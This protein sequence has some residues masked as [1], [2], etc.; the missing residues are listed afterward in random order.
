MV[1]RTLGGLAL[2]GSRLTRPKPL[3]LLAFLSLEGP[4]GRREL[5]DLFF[6]TATDPRDGLAT[7]LR[8]LRAAG[9]LVEQG[10]EHV[11]SAVEADASA[12]LRDF[13]AYR[14]QAVLERY[15]GAFL[16]G[17][18]VDLGLELEEWLFTTREAIASR[19]RTAAL[20]RARIAVG[21]GRHQ[22]ARTLTVRALRLE[23]V[24]ELEDDEI[25]LAH[26][27]AE[28]LQL[29]EAARLRALAG[30]AGLVLV[31]PTAGTAAAATTI[32]GE[33]VGLHR[34]TRF[35][36]RARELDR[37]EALCRDP[38][39]RLVTI[40]GMGGVGKT[41]LA[42]RC[43]ERALALQRARYPDGVF[44]VSLEAVDH[45]SDVPATIASALVLPTAAVA[46]PA[47]LQEA[48]ASWRSLIVLDNVEHV[49]D[50]A[51]LVVGLVDGCP[52]LQLL[53]TSR[54]RLGLSSEHVLPL[55]GLAT[56]RAAGGRSD[57]AGLFLTRAA[58]VGFDR[59][60]TSNALE[61]IEALCHDLEGY[62][63]GIELA[64][65]WT[66][67]LGIDEIRTTLRQSLDLLVEGPPDAPERHRAV[68]AALEPSWTLAGERERI[69]LQRLSVFRGGFSLDAANAVA[70]ATLPVL[71]RLVDDGL[72]RSVGGGRGRFSLHPVMRAFVREKTPPGL[73]AAASAAHVDFYARLLASARARVEREPRETLERVSTDAA[74][75][76]AALR[77][78]LHT[79]R[80]SDAVAMAQALVVDL[81][82]LQARPCPPELGE[83]LLEVVDAAEA[84]G[85]LGDVV[86]VLIKVANARRGLEADLRDA[87]RLY[88]R[89]LALAEACGDVHA[90]V[91]V[92]AILAVVGHGSDAGAAAHHLRVAE[93]L[94]GDDAFLRC[95]VMQRAGYLAFVSGDHEAARHINQEVVALAE[96]L[97][98]EGHPKAARL[99]SLLFHGLH[100]LGGALDQ[101]GAIEASLPVRERAL[102]FARERGN[103]LWTAHAHHDLALGLA[104]IERWPE[105]LKH[106]EAAS[107]LYHEHGA[108][109][110]ADVVEANLVRWRDAAARASR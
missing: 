22:D 80:T 82:V 32:R 89:A 23:G 65:S 39:T 102:A 7:A 19:V 63:L 88:R 6:S 10:E 93:D 96:R 81:D 17:V 49:Q 75:V 2:E 103:R 34:S 35:I 59:D 77:E 67:A 38:D 74:D 45:V 79:G 105:A 28:Q 36:G 29:P 21:E 15:A 1:L 97:W 108:V 71:V 4:R 83:V 94:A 87:A 13:D 5:A 73:L 90:Q 53:L 104:D 84:A 50:L 20:H 27:L 30:G 101:L 55:A 56:E 64:A 61:A 92:H 69:V 76:S 37:L 100:N 46:T 31:Q 12:L 11:A 47:G 44:V 86:G 42:L 51:P 60:V 57:A 78:A 110:E 9:A 24:P 54:R 18:T 14:Y 66:R 68:R 72:L 52:G 26:H 70:G 95:E 85:L 106:A 33:S 41:R 58:R 99:A 98:H 109:A 3:L 91:M 48:L 40:V 43:A 8:H 62:P 107:S 25:A 16:E